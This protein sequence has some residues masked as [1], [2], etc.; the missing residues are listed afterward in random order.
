[1][2]VYVI[3]RGP[4]CFIVFSIEFVDRDF[5]FKNLH[6]KLQT[7]NLKLKKGLS[8]MRQPLF[9]TNDERPTTLTANP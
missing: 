1:M 9:S 2:K 4:F 3:M 8:H 7:A 6:Y 5:K